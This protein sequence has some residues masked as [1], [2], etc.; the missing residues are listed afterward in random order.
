M[1][2]CCRSASFPIHSRP[3]HETSSSQG[4]L[5]ELSR[6]NKRQRRLIPRQ[7]HPISSRHGDLATRIGVS[8]CDQWRARR[9]PLR[10]PHRATTL[11]RVSALRA[12]RSPADG[13]RSHVRARAAGTAPRGS[14]ARKPSVAARRPRA[15]R[16]SRHPPLGLSGRRRGWAA[17]HRR[18]VRAGSATTATRCAPSAARTHPRS[19]HAACSPCKGRYRAPQCHGDHSARSPRGHRVT[20][21][22]QR[23]LTPR[24]NSN[25]MF[26]SKAN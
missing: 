1:Q 11:A 2:P 13:R 8:I 25:E 4:Q 7:P 20:T 19:M 12:D 14:G 9:R 23:P 3:R 16:S 6:S 22:H 17:G 15:G 18:R 26:G 5:V 10:P 21:P 24:S